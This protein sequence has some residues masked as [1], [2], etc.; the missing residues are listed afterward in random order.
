ML[1]ASLAM[2]EEQQQ[3]ED[4]NQEDAE[5]KVGELLAPISYR[6]KGTGRRTDENNGLYTTE[7]TIESSTFHN[8]RPEQGT[9]NMEEE[10]L[11]MFDGYQICI[12]SCS[13]D[14]GVGEL[15]SVH[16]QGNTQYASWNAFRDLNSTEGLCKD[17][18][19]KNC[20]SEKQES[21]SDS[22]LHG[23]QSVPDAGPAITRER[24]KMDIAG[25]QEIWLG[26]QRKQQKDEAK[27]A[28]YV[29]GI[30]GT[31][32]IANKQINEQSGETSGLDKRNDINEEEAVRTILVD[33]SLE[34]INPKMIDKRFNQILIQT[35]AQI[36][37]CGV[38][39]IK[40]S[41]RVRSIYGQQEAEKENWNLREILTIYGAIQVL[42]DVF[43]NC[44]SKGKISFEKSYRFDFKDRRGKWMGFNNK[45]YRWEIE[46][47][48][49]YVFKDVDDRGLFNKE[50]GIR[51]GFE[52]LVSRDNSGFIRSKKLR[53]TQEILYIE[54]RQKNRRMRF[55]ECPL[56]G[57]V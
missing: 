1:R 33:E 17:N 30:D 3:K 5:E 42:K 54:E 9:G 15:P 22:K 27:T 12:Q 53:Q 13:G 44:K 46:Q 26:N 19:I 28:T 45:T 7:R 43:P 29:P 23:R 31:T 4:F 51:G 37:G 2:G 38:S 40:N 21:S 47:R 16:A 55:K 35:N 8:E 57:R 56:G 20:Q 18:I 52:G 14:R 34:N 10:R 32:S 11:G 25:I 24:D 49:G 36:S 48:S 6:Y 39:M 50:R 41:T